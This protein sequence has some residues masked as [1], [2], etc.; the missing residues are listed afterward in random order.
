MIPAYTENRLYAL[1]FI[2]YLSIGLYIFLN[3]LTA[4]I[5]N[6]FRGYLSTSM[7]GSFFRRRV[8]ICAAFEVLKKHQ[9]N[10]N[11]SSDEIVNITLVKRLLD[12]VKIPSKHR[13]FMHQQLDMWPTDTMSREQFREFFDILYQDSTAIAP[14]HDDF[15]FS[16]YPTIRFLQ[17]L[18]LHKCFCY[19]QVMVS[20]T[21]CIILTVRVTYVGCP[22]NNFGLCVRLIFQISITISV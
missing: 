3:L 2:G 18:V 14:V 8:G 1:Y 5:Y 4:V 12:E 13:P 11:L 21:N 9:S 7:Q 20:V 10:R 16:L 19:F 15:T 17:K 6:Q 22:G